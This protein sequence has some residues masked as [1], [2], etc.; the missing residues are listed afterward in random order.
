[1]DFKVGQKFKLNTHVGAFTEHGGVHNIEKHHDSDYEA[2]LDRHYP[3]WEGQ[4]GVVVAVVP[5]E[6]EGAGNRE[7]EHVVLSMDWHDP[8]TRQA[9]AGREGHRT[10][11]FTQKQMD[12][13]FEPV[14]M[15]AIE[16]AMAADQ[17]EEA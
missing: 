13:W 4:V 3:L 14:E 5:P 10:V 2:Y 17:A 1:M 6:E 11:S 9:V 7:E 16:A 15:G 12:D 8:N